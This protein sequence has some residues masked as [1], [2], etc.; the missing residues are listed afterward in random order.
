[1]DINATVTIVY[2]ANLATNHVLTLVTIESVP[3]YV[4]NHVNRVNNRASGSVHIP[5]VPNYVAK[6]ATVKNVVNHAKVS[7]DA[8][9]Y[10]LDIVASLVQISV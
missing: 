6:Y 5:N 8:D 1:M 7:W 3:T 2:I 10:V 9:I 4:V